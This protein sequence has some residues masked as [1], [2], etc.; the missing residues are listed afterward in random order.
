[1]FDN[2]ER[3][4][5]NPYDD[6]CFMLEKFG[7]L[8]MLERYKV[9]VEKKCC[10]EVNNLCEEVSKYSYKLEV[11]RV[12]RNLRVSEIYEEAENINYTINR[13]SLWETEFNL[14]EKKFTEPFLIKED[15]VSNYNR[16][17]FEIKKVK[18]EELMEANCED[19]L[20]NKRELEKNSLKS[21]NL[22]ER[23]DCKAIVNKCESCKIK[24]CPGNEAAIKYLMCNNISIV[25]E[26]IKEYPTRLDVNL[27]LT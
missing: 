25:D 10:K 24:N 12:W 20:K 11:N 8:S 23:E 3:N 21:F 26:I 17:S 2:E 19:Y 16:N 15:D 9:G 1:M 5:V 6:V 14:I 13:K 18:N 27:L 7:A 4:L 22:L